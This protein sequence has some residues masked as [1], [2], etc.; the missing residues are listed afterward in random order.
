MRGEA[1]ENYPGYLAIDGFELMMNMK[2]QDQIA[3][4]IIL[5]GVCDNIEKELMPNSKPFIRRRQR[6]LLW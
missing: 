1:V 6:V 2:A 5:W 3:R 4:T